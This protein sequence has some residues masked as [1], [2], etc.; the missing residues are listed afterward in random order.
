[1]LELERLATWEAALSEY[2][3]A[4]RHVPFEYGENDCCTFISGAVEAMTGVDPMAEF[5]GKYDSLKGSMKALK[6]IGAGDL[7]STLDAKFPAVSVSHARRGDV[8]FFDG[9]A[10]V[11]AGS[12][13]W[14]VS[15]DGLERVPIAH[16]DKAWRVG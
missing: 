5:R 8:A 9:S 3:A 13:A 11:V 12:F 2:V 14:F 1:M 6:S 16:W 15:D 7:E 10:G 4:M